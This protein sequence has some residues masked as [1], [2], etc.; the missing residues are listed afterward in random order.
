MWEDVVKKRRKWW[1]SIFWYLDI[2]AED[3]FLGCLEKVSLMKGLLLTR[4]F[5]LTSIQDFHVQLCS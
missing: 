5:L 3:T 2:L 4:F 1:Y